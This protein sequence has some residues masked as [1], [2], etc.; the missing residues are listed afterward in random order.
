MVGGG[1]LKTPRSAGVRMVDAI[2]HEVE[3]PLFRCTLMRK[4]ILFVHSS[5]TV[6]LLLRARFDKTPEYHQW[7]ICR[8]W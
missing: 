8:V 3:K 2:G 7:G 4:S 6:V 1:S 5:S